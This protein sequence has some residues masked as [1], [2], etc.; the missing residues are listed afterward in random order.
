[1]NTSILIFSGNLMPGVFHVRACQ[2][3]AGRWNKAA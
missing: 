2:R 3:G 1:M